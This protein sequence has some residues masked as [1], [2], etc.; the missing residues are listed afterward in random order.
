MEDRL[1]AAMEYARPYNIPLHTKDMLTQMKTFGF[2]T[3]GEEEAFALGWMSVSVNSGYRQ[4][5]DALPL[6][7]QDEL[8]SNIG[9]NNCPTSS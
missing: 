7:S 4:S 1:H 6:N 8:P 5:V 2:N 9:G 3:K